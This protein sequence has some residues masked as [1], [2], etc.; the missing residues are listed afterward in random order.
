MAMYRRSMRN[1]IRALF[2]VFMVTTIGVICFIA[3]YYWQTSIDDIVLKEQEE[4]NTKILQEIKSFIHVPLAMNQRNCDFIAKGMVDMDNPAQ[5][6]K[7]FATVMENAEPNVYSFSYGTIRGEYYGVRRNMDHQLEFMKSDATT[8]GRSQYY[9]LNEDLT[10]GALRVNLGKF[11]PRSRDWY[12]VAAETGQPSFSDI[13]KH[14]V[15]NDLAL[16]ASYPI[17]K[18]GVL[19]GVLGTHITL[20]ALNQKLAETVKKSQAS[21][22]IIEKNSE[23]LVAN[24][25]GEENFTIDNQGVIDRIDSRQIQ[26]ENIKKAIEQY[27]NTGKSNIVEETNEGNFYIQ[28][29]E[30]AYS[31]LDWLIIT[32]IPEH[33]YVVAMRNSIFISL[34]LSAAAI[35]I[36]AVI[37]AKKIDHY[38]NPIYE[39]IAVTEK[40]AHGDFSCRANISQGN[41]VG[42]LGYAFN[43]M[44]EEISSLIANLEKKVTERTQE[45]E[46]RNLELAGAKQQLEL[47]LQIDF[48]TGLY[49]RKFIIGQMEEEMAAFL[50]HGE[51]FAI[52]MMDIDHFKYINDQ[53]GHD[54]GDL[55]LKETAVLMQGM[56]GTGFASRWGG[57]E[58]LLLLP[59]VRLEEAW[60]IT[61]SLRQSMEEHHFLCHKDDI[62]ATATFGIAL[63]RQG[64]NL[65]DVIKNADVA[66]Y[67][68]K[69]RG[70]N[71]VYSLEKL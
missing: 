19:M 37:W 51:S 49:N 13:Y 68:G 40:F 1:Q 34:L 67:N 50:Q 36:A 8:Q 20:D 2:I 35:I 38:L 9:Q 28:V 48:L 53:Y 16:S 5:R 17:Y 39:L 62:R 58:F 64:M 26:N 12:I 44:A 23:E 14:F 6:E 54:C 57:E 55:V 15:M 29:A 56:V 4:A 71:Q 66:L 25:A 65:D 3:F 42:R 24:T 22:Y 60:Q 43:R 61:E 18:N 7:F 30:L 10:A 45:L 70:R 59:K 47:S 41:E 63:Y 32:M 33:P 21:A 27:K 46:N 11:D 69:N 31:G 52:I